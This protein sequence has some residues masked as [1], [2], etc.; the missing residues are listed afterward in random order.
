[1][2]TIQWQSFTAQQKLKIVV[3]VEEVGNREVE[4][5]YDVDDPCMRQWRKNQ[6]SLQAAHRDRRS[7]HGPKT[8]A[9]PELETVKK[10]EVGATPCQPKWPKAFISRMKPTSRVPRAAVGFTDL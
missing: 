7:F 1:M 4:R 5:W 10:A 6:K 3:I 8:V 2:S 9:Y